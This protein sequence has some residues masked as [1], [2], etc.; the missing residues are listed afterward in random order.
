MAELELLRKSDTGEFAVCG[1]SIYD[2]DPANDPADADEWKNH[3]EIRA[4]LIRWLCVNPAAKEL[5]DPR[6]IQVYGARIRDSLDLIS[7]VA[8]FPLHLAHCR[9]DRASSQRLKSRTVEI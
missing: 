7:V 6:G 2:D 8:S 3:R 4:A 9:S 5:V 1:P